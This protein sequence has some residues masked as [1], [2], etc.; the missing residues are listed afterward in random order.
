MQIASYFFS[1]KFLFFLISLSLSLC[2]SFLFFYNSNKLRIILNY[3]VL[4]IYT[5]QE[6]FS[7]LIT[8]NVKLWKWKRFIIIFFFCYNLVRNICVKLDGNNKYRSPSVK[9]SSTTI[10]TRENEKEWKRERRVLYIFLL[11]FPY[12]HFRSSFKWN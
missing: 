2:F 3:Y 10:C 5:L 6:T 12:A 8:F 11:F 7:L 9:I 1:F 4:R